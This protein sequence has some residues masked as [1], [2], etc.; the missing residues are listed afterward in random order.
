[1]PDIHVQRHWLEP[2]VQF[3]VVIKRSGLVNAQAILQCPVQNVAER[4][5]IKIELVRDGI[6]QTDV[7]IVNRVPPNSAKTKGN[8]LTISAP[9]KIP[10]VSGHA[11]GCFNEVSLRKNLKRHFASRRNVQ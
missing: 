11:E 4:D 8:R 6:I 2:Q 7:V 5:V 9:D 10:D 1:M 3:Y